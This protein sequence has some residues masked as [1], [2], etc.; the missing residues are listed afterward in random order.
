M[1][2]Q[3]LRGQIC[4]HNVALILCGEAHEDAIDV[5]RKD[6][7]FLPKEGWI[8]VSPSDA[9]ASLLLLVPRT[10]MQKPCFSV[11]VAK[12][13]GNLS[14]K[15]AGA[16]AY[17]YVDSDDTYDDLVDESCS[18]LF[19][20]MVSSGKQKVHAFLLAME[21]IENDDVHLD[22]DAAEDEADKT[23]GHDIDIVNPAVAAVARAMLARVDEALDVVEVM[24]TVEQSSD[25]TH[26]D[27]E[28]FA[29]VE[30]AEWVDLDAEARYMYICVYIYMYM[31]Y[32]CMYVYVYMFI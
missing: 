10:R 12:Q 31:L 16:W 2:K 3:V 23:T 9:L 1:L 24:D 18:R 15:G 17:D 25:E 27:D 30:M 22:V 19:L 11:R 7:Y 29:G 14:K 4:G 8:D 13:K 6:G 28:V 5:T 32:V 21:I 26:A 20:V